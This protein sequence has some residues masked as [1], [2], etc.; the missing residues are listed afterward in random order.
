[1]D[2]L[3]G[4]AVARYLDQVAT[5]KLGLPG[6]SS[7]AICPYLKPI[8]VVCTLLPNTKTNLSGRLRSLASGIAAARLTPDIAPQECF[9]RQRPPYREHAGERIAYAAVS[10]DEDHRLL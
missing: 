8:G 6:D 4:D 2:G 1:L 7:R 3:S 5:H 9:I 10:N